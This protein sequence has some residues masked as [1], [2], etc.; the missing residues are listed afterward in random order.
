MNNS[1]YRGRRFGRLVCGIRGD[2]RS[3]GKRKISGSAMSVRIGRKKSTFNPRPAR[4]A[5]TMAGGGWRGWVVILPELNLRPDGHY[6][7]DSRVWAAVRTIG[8]RG[9]VYRG[10]SYAALSG[11][12]SLRRFR[13]RES[14]G[15]SAAGLGWDNRLVLASQRQISTFG[16]D[17]SG[18]LYLA[19]YRGDIY[20]ITAGPPATAQPRLSMR[21]VLP[22]GISA[23]SLATVFGAGITSFPGIVQA[24]GFPLP[25]IC[26]GS[27]SR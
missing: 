10:S 1:A 17:E 5:R 2:S 21:P 6:A 3:T 13:Q 7:S 15:G 24:G 26:P 8:D 12:L 25:A 20:R 14:L 9:F 18:E 4:A 27:Q 22:A 19:D 23:G 11:F 16:E